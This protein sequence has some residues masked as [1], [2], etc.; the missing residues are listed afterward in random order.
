MGYVIEILSPLSSSVLINMGRGATKATKKFAASG[1]LKKT[2]Q[3]RHK[4]QQIQKKIQGRKGKQEHK[5]QNRSFVTEGAQEDDED[6]GET[7]KAT[8]RLVSVVYHTLTFE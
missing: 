1:Q 4:R 8:K 5:E 3:A 2:I 6:D 7:S